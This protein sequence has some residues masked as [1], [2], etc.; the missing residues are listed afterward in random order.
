MGR[1]RYKIYETTHPHFFTCTILN[2]LL[3]RKADTTKTKRVKIFK[4]TKNKL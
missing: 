3:V 2:W 4:L 1:S